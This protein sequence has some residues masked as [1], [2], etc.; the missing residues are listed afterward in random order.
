LAENFAT[1]HPAS[2]RLIRK[3]ERDTMELLPVGST[4]LV[5]MAHEATKLYMMRVVN[6]INESPKV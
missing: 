5:N 2:Q 1:G 4:T 3:L 6:H